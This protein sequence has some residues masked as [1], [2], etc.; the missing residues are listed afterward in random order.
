MRVYTLRFERR[1]KMHDQFCC[2]P[3]S[4]L[5]DS[6][7]PW[8]ITLIDRSI[9]R[10]LFY[11]L[12]FD[13]CLNDL[14]GSVEFHSRTKI[15]KSWKSS[16][17]RDP[18]ATEEGALVSR[19]RWTFYVHRNPPDLDDVSPQRRNIR[20]LQKKA[21]RAGEWRK[22]QWGLRKR[23]MPEIHKIALS[24]GRSCVPVRDSFISNLCVC[25]L[26]FPLTKYRQRREKKT[27]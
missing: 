1:I 13:E 24:D 14:L 21:E 16:N 11:D 23:W 9:L 4:G 17:N 22:L 7:R 12:L 6:A 18:N 26:Q 27:R 10:H 20:L 3:N 19:F 15:G 25:C 5:T 8:P 2:D